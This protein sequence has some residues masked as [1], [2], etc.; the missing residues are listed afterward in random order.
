MSTEKHPLDSHEPAAAL[1]SPF[2]SSSPRTTL[3]LLPPELKLK[4]VEEVAAE[5][6]KVNYGN[7]LGPSELDFEANQLRRAKKRPST[8]AKVECGEQGVVW[9]EVDLVHR[10]CRSL[11]FFLRDF[12][13]RHG[14]HIRHFCIVSEQE[15]ELL[16]FRTEPS[17]E[18]RRATSRVASMLFEWDINA[19][20]A[21]E[22]GAGETREMFLSYALCHCPN[23]EA[24]HLAV[25]S[26]VA[27]SYALHYLLEKIGDW[28]LQSLSLYIDL[29]VSSHVAAFV[30]ILA[31]VP[32]LE[33]LRLSVS[34]T[35]PIPIHAYNEIMPAINRLKQLHTLSLLADRDL[36]GWSHAL[37]KKPPVKFLEVSTNSHGPNFVKY[38]Y[39]TVESFS[40]TL[41]VLKAPRCR[42]LRLLFEGL[43]DDH[44]SLLH[45]THLY[46]DDIEA[47]PSTPHELV[48]Y[49][50]LK[51]LTFEQWNEGTAISLALLIPTLPKLKAIHWLRTLARYCQQS[52]IQIDELP[53]VKLREPLEDSEEESER[54]FEEMMFGRQR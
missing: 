34:R 11:V 25:L 28:R 33:R 26:D 43:P 44:L 32:S 24:V 5:V 35:L 47:S 1:P 21:S 7:V 2:S 12:L 45:L 27:R 31:K 46:C 18:A 48:M 10:S 49:P 51:S 30:A 14:Q 29:T 36:F 50:A 52:D 37:I 9:A 15:D 13:P 17:D 39:A 16:G 3:S 54:K 22:L 4:I 8:F 42:L 41:T 6:R 38:L 40:R 20:E 19:P 53:N 23:L